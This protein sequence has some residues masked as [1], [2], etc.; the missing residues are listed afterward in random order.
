MKKLTR[1][2]SA[3]ALTLGALGSAQANQICATCLYGPGATYVGSYNALT[4]DQGIFTNAVAVTGAP[5][6]HVWVFDFAPSGSTS[7][8]ANF[9]PVNPPA[10]INFQVSL[11]DATGATCNALPFQPNYVGF[12]GSCSSVPAFGAGTLIA[13]GNQGNG[14]SAVNLTAVA[15]G[16]YAW[17]VVGQAVSVGGATTSQYSGQMNTYPVPEPATL[18]LVGAALVA[19]AA[20]M[21]RRRQQA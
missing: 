3:L 11:H 2:A 18:G 7:A 6:G 16:R 19:G 5:F 9:N 15:A 13:T 20:A 14:A 17:I 21:R 4:L 12:G 8:S 1:L 10:F